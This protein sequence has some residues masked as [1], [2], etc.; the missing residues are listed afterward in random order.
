M[1]SP[2]QTIDP[3]E[4]IAA[5]E[6]ENA[7]LKRRV[8]SFETD[9]EAVVQERVASAMAKLNADADTKAKKK[10]CEMM[11]EVG[12]PAPVKY[13]HDLNNTNSNQLTGIAKAQAYFR[14]K[15]TVSNP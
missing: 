14:N 4:Y 15:S 6:A 1:N 12:Q 9:T 7:V 11:A 10:A 2:Q 8:A 5:L 13:S 3:I